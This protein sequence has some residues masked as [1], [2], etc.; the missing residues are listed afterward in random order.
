MKRKKN[1]LLKL[2]EEE[3]Q[4]A[5]ELAERDHDTISGYLRRLLI[6]AWRKEKGEEK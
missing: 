2:T 5:R 4:M 1:I 6:M 3:H